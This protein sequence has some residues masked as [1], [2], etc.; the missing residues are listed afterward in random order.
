MFTRDLLFRPISGSIAGIALVTVAAVAVPSGPAAATETVLYTFTGQADGGLPVGDL[1]PGPHGVLY[2]TTGSGGTGTDCQGGCGTV[3]EL[4][5][6][7]AA[8]QPW[9]EEVLHSFGPFAKG[10]FPGSL[11]AGPLGALYGATSSGGSLDNACLQIDQ[12]SGC[13][14]VFKLTPPLLPGGK[15]HETVL[16]RF[17][18]VNGDGDS[19]SG[20]LLLDSSGAVYGTT[21]FGGLTMN[22][23]FGCGTVFKLTPPAAL[24]GHWTEEILYSFQ[25]GADGFSPTGGLIADASGALYGTTGGS[26]TDNAG[27]VYKLIPPATVGAAWTKQILYKF[28]G[29]SDG[30]NPAGGLVFDASGALYG[31]APNGGLHTCDSSILSC[32]VV[33]QLT[34]PAGADGAWTEQVLHEFAGGNNDGFGP[35]TG[36]TIGSDGSVYGTTPTGA[37]SGCFFLTGCGTVYKLTPPAGGG[38]NWPEQILYT[39]TGSADG[40]EPSGGLTVAPGGA[41]YGVASAGGGFGQG[42][43]YHLTP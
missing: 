11:V 13:G 20:P 41:F 34:P 17:T 35:S 3:F 4:V 22:G 19:P 6:P 43:V 12:T 16:H 24:G 1:V 40:G 25:G 5:P 28:T 8:G 36:V 31:T 9:T 27:T 7:I 18:S 2:G 29:G 30:G 10:Q 32:G 42:V 14:V 37:G 38:G 23:C 33:F 39:F 15:W 21:A 26:T